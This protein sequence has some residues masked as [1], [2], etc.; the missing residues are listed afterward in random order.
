MNRKFLFLVLF[1]FPVLSFSWQKAKPVAP[2]WVQEHK[3]YIPMANSDDSDAA[4]LFKS[5][6]VDFRNGDIQLEKYVVYK[7]LHTTG[8]TRGVLTISYSAGETVQDIGG[9]RLDENGICVEKLEKKNV[10]KIALNENFVDDERQIIATFKTLDKGDVVAF[11]YKRTLKSFFRDIFLP[12]GDDSVIDHMEITVSGSPYLAV[13]NDPGH[14]VQRKGNVFVVENQP[15]TKPEVMDPPFPDKIPYLGISYNTLSSDWKSFGLQYWKQ[16]SDR[17]QLDKASLDEIA[18]IFPEKDPGKLIASVSRWVPTHINYVDIE[19]GRGGIIPHSCNVVLK[20]RYGDCKDMTFLAAA[21]LRSRGISAYPVMAAVHRG[22]VF[23]KFPGNQFNHVILAVKLDEKTKGLSNLQIGKTP[24]LIADMTSRITRI[25]FL[26]VDLEGSNALLVTEKGG[27]LIQLPHSSAA[28]N[29]IQYIIIGHLNPNKSLV[30]EIT[31]I[32][33]GQPAYGELAFRDGISKQEE[34][35]GYRNWIQRMIPGAVLIDF[36]VIEGSD[37][38]KT[39]CHINLQ[40]AGIEAK[41]GTY[42][43]PNLVDIGSRNHFRHKRR[44]PVEFPE[45]LTRKVHV[46]LKLSAGLTV[47]KAPEN[48]ELDTPYYKLSRH[49][50]LTGNTFAMDFVSVRKKIR[51]PLDEYKAF[52]KAYR[53]YLRELKAPLLVR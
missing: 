27:R 4:L 2:R 46:V 37:V 15:Y 22:K 26:P 28:T 41:D 47:K 42:V 30:A 48:S 31:E 8:L 23:P 1:L 45:Y 17:L 35:E 10:R 53:H 12:L 39:V 5:T 49:C 44:F 40:N 29:M 18:R 13:L 51:I 36:N 34:K 33:T 19:L 24:F 11:H 7:I 6:F 43:I 32:K 20:H 9:W 21:I 38:V 16:A 50:S 3:T 14:I 52:R 25:P